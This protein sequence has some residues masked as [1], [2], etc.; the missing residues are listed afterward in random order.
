L[1]KVF[2]SRKF[3]LIRSMHN[4]PHVLIRRSRTACTRRVAN[5][6]IIKADFG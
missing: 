2:R 4:L 5:Q 3:L 1:K 6:N